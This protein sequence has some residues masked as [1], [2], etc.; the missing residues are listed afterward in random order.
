MIQHG[1]GEQVGY[2]CRVPQRQVPQVHSR[3]SHLPVSTGGQVLK[4]ATRDVHV[5]QQEMQAGRWTRDAVDP[6]GRED[7]IGR[8]ISLGMCFVSDQTLGVL[9][10]SYTKHNTRF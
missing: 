6:T 3:T 2:R 1:K 10:H 9:C 5:D 7:L 4:L 8:P